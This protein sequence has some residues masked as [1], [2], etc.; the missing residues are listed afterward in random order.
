MASAKLMEKK[1][2]LRSGEGQVASYS[3]ADIADGSGVVGFDGFVSVNSTTTAYHINSNPLNTGARAIVTTNTSN[4]TAYNF[5]ALPFN[6][7]RT[8]KGSASITFTHAVF[9]GASG[10]GKTN[11]VTIGVY[12]YDGTTETLLGS[13]VSPTVTSIEN[14]LVVATRQLVISLTQK[15]FKIGETLRIKVTM[16][17][18][19]GAG[20]YT[21]YFGTDPLNRNSETYQ[22]LT[23]TAANNPSYFKI[24]IPF[25]I[26]L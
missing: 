18:A 21:H 3:W 5:D 14:V 19:G 13:A 7:P 11:I 2:F 6:T 4:T 10:A 9:G 23:T 16:D 20:N 26:D 22:S 1:S 8:I 17:W 12:H 15:S 24:N 25:R